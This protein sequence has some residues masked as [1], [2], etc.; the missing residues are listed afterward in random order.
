LDQS[1]VM[2]AAAARVQARQ[3][4]RQARG[5]ALAALLSGGNVDSTLIEPLDRQIQRA[6]LLHRD[7]LA[8]MVSDSG[9]SRTLFEAVVGDNDMLPSRFLP[10]GTLAAQTVGRITVR[11]ANGSGLYGTGSLVGTNIVMTNNHVLQ[12]KDAAANGVF[13]LGYYDAAPGGSTPVPQTF[14]LQPDDLFFT[15]EELDFT[16]VGVASDNGSASIASYGHLPLIADSGKAL[17]GE[18]LNIIQHAEG[19]PQQIA[20]R[21]N[22]LVDV[23]AP[24]LHYQTDTAPGSSGSPVFNDDWQLV[25]LHHAAVQTNTGGPGGIVN[26]GIQISA[27]MQKLHQVFDAG[28]T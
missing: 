18:K 10:L 8:N 7:D 21:A 17:V 22:M 20:I 19:G 25:A 23:L 16:L 14:Q 6:R 4:I 12:S 15:D 5:M 2:A 24:Y 11:N 27:I 9:A 1:S 28:Y 13:E 26:E 3:P